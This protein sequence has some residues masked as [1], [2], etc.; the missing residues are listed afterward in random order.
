MVASGALCIGD[1]AH[2]MSPV[3]GVGINL[4]IQD[5]VAAEYFAAAA[6]ARPS[7]GG[8]FAESS[9]TP[10][11]SDPYD[12]A[13][14]DFRRQ[15][16]YR[17]RAGDSDTDSA[18][19]TVISTSSDVSGVAPYPGADVGFGFRPEHVHKPLLIPRPFRVGVLDKN[20]ADAILVLLAP[21][22]EMHHVSAQRQYAR[23]R[24]VARSFNHHPH[25]GLQS[26]PTIQREVRSVQTHIAHRRF[27]FERRCRLQSLRLSSQQISIAAASP[28]AIRVSPRLRRARSWRSILGRRPRGWKFLPRRRKESVHYLVRRIR[29]V[30][31]QH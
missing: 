2:A 17:S 9:G 3:G 30:M 23:S 31:K 1:S 6:V 26:R 7:N 10:R 4:A 22:I 25:F 14:A 28:A 13:A 27:F 20:D 16:R 5:A 12:S 18:A 24:R 11:I 29:I 21:G 19:S 15:A 8:R